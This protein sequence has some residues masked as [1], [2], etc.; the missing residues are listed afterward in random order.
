MH[1]NFQK[2]T[3]QDSQTNMISKVTNGFYIHSEYE[4]H[5]VLKS[6]Q[7]YV[8]TI[9]PIEDTYNFIMHG[10]LHNTTHWPSLTY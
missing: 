6:Y 4:Q 3:K 5:S 10:S 8:L 2:S 9:K 7:T 1:V